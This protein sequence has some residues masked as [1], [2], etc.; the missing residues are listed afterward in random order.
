MLFDAVAGDVVSCLGPLG[1]P[2]TLVDAPAE[3]WMVAGGVGLAPFATRDGSAACARNADDAVLR[4]ALSD[5]SSSISTGF[6]PRASVS[7]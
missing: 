1:R 7:C 4:R 5:K 2:F 6:A 3:A